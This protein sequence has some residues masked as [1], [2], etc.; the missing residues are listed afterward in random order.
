[1]NLKK[2]LKGLA[3]YV[4]YAKVSVIDHQS[5][6]ALSVRGMVTSGDENRDKQM[7]AA[8]QTV[9]VSILKLAEYYKNGVG[10]DLLDP[11]VDVVPIYERIVGYLT[12]VGQYLGSPGFRSLTAAAKAEYQNLIL[13]DAFTLE[14]LADG[15]YPLVDNYD[16]ENKVKNKKKTVLDIFREHIQTG[17][18]YNQ[19]RILDEHNDEY[20]NINNAA[21]RVA[22]RTN[23]PVELIYKYED[24]LEL[25]L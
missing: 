11:E 22:L 7:M 19:N 18:E 2:E 15:L 3:N 1:M 9:R 5:D 25:N 24:M 12:L 8:A 14:Y 16:L 13:K 10:F 4:V 23:L 17:I 6:T 21:H 20:N